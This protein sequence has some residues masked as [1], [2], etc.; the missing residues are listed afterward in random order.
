MLA[1][2]LLDN[3]QPFSRDK[4]L[5]PNLPVTIKASVDNGMV[6]EIMA[7][8]RDANHKDLALSNNGNVLSTGNFDDG[9]IS[10]TF[11]LPTLG[12][13][14][15]VIWNTWVIYS[16]P[17]LTYPAAFKLTVDVTQGGK[18]HTSSIQAQIAPKDSIVGVKVDGLWIG[19]PL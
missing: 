8:V 12:G 7:N 6:A 18:T 4:I 15:Y 19:A 13:P 2:I 10:I 3:S 9:I 11:D 17:P 1:K 16:G 5:D 14:R